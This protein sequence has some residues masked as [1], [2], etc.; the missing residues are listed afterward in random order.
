[1]ILG[2]DKGYGSP[3]DIFNI[4]GTHPYRIMTLSD[5]L[6]NSAYAVLFGLMGLIA[7]IWFA[8]FLYRLALHNIR[9]TNASTVSLLIIVLV[10]LAAIGLGF[11]KGRKMLEDEFNK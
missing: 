3:F 8:D 9:S 6:K 2:Y 11:T 10:L 5:I 1:M 4:P 7:G